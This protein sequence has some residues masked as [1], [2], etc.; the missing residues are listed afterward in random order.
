[1]TAYRFR[2]LKEEVARKDQSH[3]QLRKRVAG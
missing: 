1:M 2:A 3:F